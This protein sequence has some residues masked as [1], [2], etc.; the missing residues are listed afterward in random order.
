[1]D[2]VFIFFKINHLV[3]KDGTKQAELRFHQKAIN[4]IIHSK[5]AKIIIASSND[6]KL[7]V[8]KKKFKNSKPKSCFN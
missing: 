7:S 1:M 8:C 4:G 3:L 6:G 5:A 2:I